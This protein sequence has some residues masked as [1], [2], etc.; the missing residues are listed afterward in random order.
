MIL[1]YNDS[2][3]CDL[4]WIPHVRWPDRVQICNDIQEYVAADCATKIAFTGHRLHVMH[5]ADMVFEDKIQLLSDHSLSVFTL[6]SELHPDHYYKIWTACHRPNVYWVVPGGVNDR[7]DMIN[8]IIYWGDWFKTTASLYRKLS[9]VLVDLHAPRAKSYHFEA[10]LGS[11]KPHR[12]FVARSVVDHGLQSKF[13]LTYGGAWND[14]RFYAQDYFIYEPGTEMADPDNHIGTMDWARYRGEQ[15]HLSQIIP[16]QVYNDSYYSVIAETD[17]VNEIIFF[18]EKTVKPIL[19]KRLFVVFSGYRFLE[20]LRSL[21]FQTFDGIIDESYDTILD[22]PSRWA[23]AF[24]QIKFLCETDPAVVAQQIQPIVEHNFQ[25][26][27][28]TDWNRYA[29]DRIQAVIDRE[30]NSAQR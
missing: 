21:G 3:I 4:E 6:E 23:A 27:M 14:D 29:I 17:H 9:D 24:E 11:P 28:E 5:D 1:V 15:C 30:T 16:T 13:I 2:Q 7:D 18:S 26:M 8:N 25:H 19:A 22:G 12:D 10:L 20:H